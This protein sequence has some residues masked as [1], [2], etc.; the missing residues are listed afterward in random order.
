MLGRP[1]CDLR[2]P[3]AVAYAARLR[4]HDASHGRSVTTDR[5]ARRDAMSTINSTPT[6][7][8]Q[9][10]YTNP[11]YD[12]PFADPFVFRV[13]STYYA[14]GSGDDE[15]DW[16]PAKLTNARERAHVIPILRSEDFVHWKYLGRALVPHPDDCAGPFW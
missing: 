7:A 8:D 11:V 2:P 5:I 13:G 3:L 9:I 4:Y 12:G 14:V 6:A 16:S 15:A 1:T 10:T